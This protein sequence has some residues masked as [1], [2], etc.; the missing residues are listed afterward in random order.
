SPLAGK[1]SGSETYVEVPKNTRK[2]KHPPQRGVQSLIPLVPPLL[3]CEDV[4]MRSL[5]K[6]LLTLA[7]VALVSSPALAQ[8]PQRPQPGAGGPGQLSGAALLANKSVQ[9]ELKLTE[10][11]TKK[12]E[13][14]RKAVDD[15]FKD[16]TDKLRDIRDRREQAEKRAEINK[17]KSEETMKSLSGVL[18]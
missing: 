4:F 17:K 15:K 14:T 10:D 18:K 16:E 9:E 7:V 12:I 8:R 5:V 1:S 13:E 2:A 6:M 11:Q 3:F